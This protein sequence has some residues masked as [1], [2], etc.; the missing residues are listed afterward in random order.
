MDDDAN[1][2]TDMQSFTKF[3]ITHCGDPKKYASNSQ[4]TIKKNHPNTIF[5]YEFKRKGKIVH[6]L[7][8]SNEE[9]KVSPYLEPKLTST[10]YGGGNI[11]LLKPTGLNRGRGIEL[12]NT[13]EDLN[14]HINQYLEGDRSPKK[15]PQK[16]NNESGAE[17]GSDEESKQNKKGPPDAKFKSHTFVIQ[18]YIEHPLLVYERKFDIRAYALVTHDMQ[19]YFFKYS[20]F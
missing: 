17:S 15:K 20:F 14:R 3:F 4:S 18:K 13:L 6:I 1:F 5:T 7:Q 2:E 16:G 11:W 12:F 9:K 10:Y 19:L 8:N